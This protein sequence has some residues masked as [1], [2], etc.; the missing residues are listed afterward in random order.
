MG[1]RVRS[2]EYD[3]RISGLEASVGSMERRL[4]KLGDNLDAHFDATRRQFAD[5]SE[6]FAHSR[7][8]SWGA[9]AG[10]AAVV[11][12]IVALGGSSYVRDVDRLAT[13]LT[14]LQDSFVQHIRDGHPQRTEARLDVLVQRFETEIAAARAVARSDT[15]HQIDLRTDVLRRL[16]SL[17]SRL[18][19]QR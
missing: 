17:E 5:L 6:R 16:D 3:G 10:W 7:Q 12:S 8:T 9:L 4:D 13:E 18:D 14:R 19:R 1:E 2:D 11:V 15:A